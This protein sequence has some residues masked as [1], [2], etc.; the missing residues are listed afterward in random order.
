MR[1]CPVYGLHRACRCKVIFVL[2]SY[3]PFYAGKHPVIP[4]KL[5]EQSGII[6]V[7][8]IC[9][10]RYRYS[11]RPLITQLWPQQSIVMVRIVQPQYFCN[12][13][14][15]HKVPSHQKGHCCIHRRPQQSGLVIGQPALK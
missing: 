13:S 1:P 14:F 8:N 12:N 6:T 3:S 11:I 2:L 5:P 10:E 9:A 15:I 7:K 4:G